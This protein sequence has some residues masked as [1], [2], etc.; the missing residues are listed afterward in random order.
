[1]HEHVSKHIKMHK[2]P[3]GGINKHGKHNI[4]RRGKEKGMHRVTRHPE[5]PPKWLHPNMTSS[6]SDVTTQGQA[7]GRRQ[8]WQS[9]ELERL[10]QA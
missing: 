6:A 1:M 8:T 7:R 2:K 5:M 4:A 9:L 3:T 10:I